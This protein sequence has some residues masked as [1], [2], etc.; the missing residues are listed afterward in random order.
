MSEGPDE[1]SSS[2]NSRSSDRVDPPT[3]ATPIVKLAD[4]LIES[5]SHYRASDI[6]IEPFAESLRVR[7]RIDGSLVDADNLPLSYHGPLVSRLKIM[8]G[9]NIVERR[10]PQDG[11]FSTTCNGRSLDVRLATLSTIHGEKIVLRLLD[12]RRTTRGLGELGMT[13]SAVD[14]WRGLIRSPFGL[15][16]CC[17][18]TGSGKTTTLYASLTDMEIGDRN[19]TTIEDPVEYVIAGIN[20][21]RTNDQAGLTFASG[22]RALLRQDPDVILIGE[23]RDQETA[24]LGVQA[25]LTG[26][27]VLSSIHANDAAGALQRL[28]DMGVEPFLVSSSLIGVIGQRLV[29]RVCTACSHSYSPNPDE[30]ELFH[31][32]RPDATTDFRRGT[33]CSAC[34]HT[35]YLDR[36]GVY[37][38]LRVTPEIRRHL[39]HRADAQTIRATALDEGMTS[40]R[41]AAI[42]LVE[43]GVTTIDEVVRSLGAQSTP[44]QRVTMA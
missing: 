11:Q 21:V 17:G 39:L 10:R 36:V 44:T 18:P 41:T 19:V 16:L 29:R 43:R 22:L 32:Y 15:V 2:G 13:P 14:I 9:M 37:E 27:F 23:L 3:P 8:G 28:I 38:I 34:S 5:G 26:H 31:R 35:G 7:F 1:P 30:L 12:Q 20:Q 25:A 33:G 4:R 40:L 6:H 24:R 42:H